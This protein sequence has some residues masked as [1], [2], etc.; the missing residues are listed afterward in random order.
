MLTALIAT[1]MPRQQAYEAVQRLAMQSWESRRPFP[2]LVRADAAMREK[3]G[4]QLDERAADGLFDP[5]FYLRHEDEIY[6][7]VLGH[8]G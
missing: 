4:A 2:E 3:L 1:G 6:A 8:Q 5:A 7:R